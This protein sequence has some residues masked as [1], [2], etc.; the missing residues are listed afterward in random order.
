MQAP[1]AAFPDRSAT[2]DASEHLD[3]ARWPLR[4]ALPVVA[5]VSGGLWLLIYRGVAALV[6]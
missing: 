2:F 5:G 6:S 4:L 3:D 1:D